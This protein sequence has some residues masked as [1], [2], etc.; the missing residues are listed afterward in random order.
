MK[1]NN[2]ENSIIKHPEKIILLLL[3]PFSLFFLLYYVDSKPLSPL[4]YIIVGLLYVLCIFRKSKVY[5][6]GLL[7]YIF[8]GLFSVLFSSMLIL[9]SH[10]V[11]SGNI[12]GH[13][14]SNYF[15]S[16]GKRDYIAILL[17]SILVY[18]ILI[19]LVDY[20]IMFLNS[21]SAR[22]ESAWFQL[23]GKKWIIIVFLVLIVVWGIGYL[24]FWPGTSMWNDIDAILAFGPVGESFRSPVLYNFVVYFFLVVICDP[25]SNPNI[26]FALCTLC[27]MIFMASVVTYVLWW[28]NSVVKIRRSFFLVLFGYF[29]FYPLISL[30]SFSIV[31]DTLY[32]LFLFLWL[33]FLYDFIKEEKL[34]RRN[35]ILYCILV[36]GAIA[37]RNNGKIVV[38]LLILA[39]VLIIRKHW[40]FL[41]I[42]GA[43]ILLFVTIFTNVITR[44]VPYRFAESV[45]MPLQQIAMVLSYDGEIS[46]EDK[47]FLFQI[48]E[49]EYWVGTD[50]ASY[51]PMIV[52]T[53]KMADDPI[54]I[55]SYVIND[56]FLNEHKV[57]FIQTYL[58]IFVHNPSL[59]IK[60]WLMNSY[61][62]WAIGT[63]SSNQSNMTIIPTHYYNYS[64]EPKLPDRIN[65]VVRFYYSKVASLCGSAGTFIWIVF[66]IALIFIISKKAKYIL[67]LLPMLLNW[68]TIIVFTPVAFGFRYVFYYLLIIPVLLLL[69]PS[70][71]K[72]DVL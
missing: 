39:T 5:T 71:F 65:N 61:G 29:A 54:A 35:Q 38:P 64:Q 31:K 72:K 12:R 68:L 46:D 9:K 14:D 57:E 30:Y 58:R 36:V 43:S 6:S 4:I 23:Q 8:T 19:N 20:I 3:A 11:Y 32:S 10:I 67:L 60:A 70:I 27:Q 21:F 40:K 13:I 16:I 15:T 56:D 50:E 26:G 28:A 66:L 25:V 59:C 49:E 24:S 2:S 33:P 34:C 7:A 22:K 41:V 52:D 53:L 55:N 51:S 63:Y 18:V 17:L 69:I 1:N 48:K 42:A 37:F 62:F 44:N 47:E 45:S